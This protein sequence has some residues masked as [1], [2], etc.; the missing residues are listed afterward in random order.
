MAQKVLVKYRTKK[1]KGPELVRGFFYLRGE[2]G[3]KF[4]VSSSMLLKL[5]STF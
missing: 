1:L 5:K 2:V 3:L 4:K